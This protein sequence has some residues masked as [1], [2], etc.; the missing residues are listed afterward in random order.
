MFGLFHME[1][2]QRLNGVPRDSHAQRRKAQWLRAMEVR[3]E[4]AKKVAR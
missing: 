4:Q 1:L 3:E 2:S